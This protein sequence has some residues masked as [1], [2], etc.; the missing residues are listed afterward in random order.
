[1]SESYKNTEDPE[2]QVKHVEHQQHHERK[3]DADSTT[4]EHSEA[5]RQSIED[6]SKKVEQLSVSGAEKHTPA[7]EKK[8]HPILVNKHLKD[9]S[10]NRTML[11]VQK[12]LS[13]PN[14]YFSRAIHSP[15][16]DKPS[17]FASKTIARPS[18]MLGGAFIAMLGS[19]AL[20]V[21]VR[22]YGYEYNYL[23]IAILFLF[24]MLF[25]LLAEGA[26]RLLRR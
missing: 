6:I 15:I 21:V 1:M 17:E 22:Y 24:G 4:L 12:K 13:L 23:A 9:T 7:V 5:P 8:H 25:G 16:L 2:F 10:Y 20:Y 11:R 18:A 3:E 26:I 19:F 14:R